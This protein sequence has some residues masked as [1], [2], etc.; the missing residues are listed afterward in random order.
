MPLYIAE[1][2]WWHQPTNQP[3][4]E[5][6][7][8]WAICLFES[9]KIKKNRD[10]L[11]I[12]EIFI[13]II[14]CT[15]PANTAPNSA[16]EPI[17]SARDFFGSLILRHLLFN[18]VTNGCYARGFMTK[19]FWNPGNAKKGG[20]TPMPRFVGGFEKKVLKLNWWSRKRL[21]MKPFPDSITMFWRAMNRHIP[22]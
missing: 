9:W 1:K 10:L 11:F 4:N 6:G 17:A 12:Y 19:R 7:E 16:I 22:V 13:S 5:K 8:Y 15:S 20:G 21:V 18:S 14:Y 2:K 3:T